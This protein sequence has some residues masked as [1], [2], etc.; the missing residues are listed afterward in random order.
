MEMTPQE[1]SVIDAADKYERAQ[2]AF[3]AAKAG[4]IMAGEDEE[5][6]IALGALGAA[7]REWR[8][9]AFAISEVG[10]QEIMPELIKAKRDLYLP[11]LN[12]AMKDH[13]INTPLRASAFLAQLAHESAELKYMEEIWGPTAAQ[14][15]YEGR[16]DLGN[17]QLGDGK[18]FKGRGPIQLTGRANYKTFGELLGVDFVGNPDLAATPEWG[19]LTAALYWKR[20]GLNELADVGDFKTITKRINGGYNGLADRERYYEVAKK[21]L[22]VG[23]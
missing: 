16:K 12:E 6:M 7:V 17:T 11:F 13:E 21:A 14:K 15:R 20:K 9:M 5:L 3:D 23:E 18:R 1:R 19:F 8:L 4:L 2:F 22:G 10:L